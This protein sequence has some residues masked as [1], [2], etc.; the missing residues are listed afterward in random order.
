[1]STRRMTGTTYAVLGLLAV[2]PWSTYE[3]DP[4]DGTDP[5][6]AS[7]R[8]PRASSTKSRRSSS[9]SGCPRPRTKPSAGDPA[10]CTPSQTPADRPSQSGCASPARAR[11]WNSSSWSSSA[12]PTTEPA[13]TPADHLSDLRVGTATQRGEPRSQG[14]RRRRRPIPI[15]RRARHAGRRLLHRLLRH[16]RPLGNLGTRATRRN[17]QKIPLTQSPTSLTSPKSHNE[18]NGHR[19]QRMRRGSAGS[20]PVPRE[21][22][23]ETPS[24]IGQAAHRPR[25]T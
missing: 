18:P 15:P 25:P 23:L 16:G 24:A 22:P 12:S 14:L 5:R 1:M 4:T 7:G 17:G 9:N 2:Q 3:F 20:P 8:Q 6:V 10:P 11:S 21:R 13:K 19:D